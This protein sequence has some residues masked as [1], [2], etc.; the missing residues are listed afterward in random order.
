MNFRA[1]YWSYVWT[2]HD[3]RS[4]CL[5]LL[6]FYTAYWGA[7]LLSDIV[8]FILPAGSL[9]GP[10]PC[11]PPIP[12]PLSDLD[13]TRGP[14]HYSHMCPAKHTHA[15]TVRIHVPLCSS[16]QTLLWKTSDQSRTVSRMILH[17]G[18]CHP[19]TD[20]HIHSPNVIA[21]PPSPSYPLS[22][23]PPIT[24]A[25]PTC[26]PLAPPHHLYPGPSNWYEPSQCCLGNNSVIET[27]IMC[28]HPLQLLGLYMYTVHTEDRHLWYMVGSV[29]IIYVQ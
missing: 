3:L 21:L 7:L 5:T 29:F 2:F 12:T 19:V 4:H 17:L 25:L 15:Y 22:L 9:G 28:L 10:D 1:A 6:S 14:C 13:R 23:H 16:G 20:R 27:R 11:A 26:P 18:C 24:S 8:S